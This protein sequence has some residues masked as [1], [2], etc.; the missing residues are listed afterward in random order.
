MSAVQFMFIFVA[1]QSF[2]RDAGRRAREVPRARGSG[3]ERRPE[4]KRYGLAFQGEARRTAE[5]EAELA[6]LRTVR[7]KRNQHEQRAEGLAL[8]RPSAT[9]ANT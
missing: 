4:L 1:I 5:A 3:A 9:I 6:T 7:V 2:N 8:T